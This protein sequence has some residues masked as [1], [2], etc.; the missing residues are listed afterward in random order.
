MS[1]L[2][3]ICGINS[4]EA[5][6]AAVRA[7]ADLAGLVF[8]PKSPRHLSL[9]AARALAERMRGR[10]RIVALVADADDATIAAVAQAVQPV[11][12]QLHGKEAPERTGQVRARFG[13][14]VIKAIS[15]AE[16][17]DF[18]AVPEYEIAADLLLFDAKAPD[19]A[20]R[21]GGHGAA[22]DWQ[23]LRG[24]SFS[25]PWLLA[26]GLTPDNVARAIA[27][28]GAP[29]VDVSSGVETAPG[30]KSTQLIADFV[31]AARKAQFAEAP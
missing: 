7:G 18:D 21:P 13:L 20:P 5:A 27:A 22:F 26:G 9:D 14:P 11:Y 12:L 24:R 8:H 16:A 30:V 28:S 17:A 1:I 23:L 3:K 31:S 29:G 25:H 10:L 4:A 2:V 6:D 19:G 15:I